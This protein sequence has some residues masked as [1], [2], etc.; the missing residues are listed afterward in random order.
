MRF[1][2]FFLKSLTFRSE[3]QMQRRDIIEFIKKEQVS[4]HPASNAKVEHKRGG[5]RWREKEKRVKGRE[6]FR[7]RRWRRKM[8]NA[9]VTLPS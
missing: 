1:S 4:S 7:E 3:T 2:P 9:P 8:E 5:G 6:K